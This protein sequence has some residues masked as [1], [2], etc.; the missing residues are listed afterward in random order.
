MTCVLQFAL[1]TAFET[2]S[3]NCVEALLGGIT[4]VFPRDFEMMIFPGL[5]IPDAV[6][7]ML[8][9]RDVPDPFAIL[10]GELESVQLG[11]FGAGGT[12]TGTVVT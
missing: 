3:T 10:E 1:P 11:A 8:Q 9:M 7:A 5:M 6:L 12:I 4:K 2:V